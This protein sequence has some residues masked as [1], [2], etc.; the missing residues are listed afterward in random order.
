MLRSRP[1]QISATCSIAARRCAPSD[2]GSEEALP[3][4][5]PIVDDDVGASRRPAEVL[6]L[7]DGQI[8]FADRSAGRDERLHQQ[9]G[10]REH[11]PVRDRRAGID[12][13]GRVEPQPADRIGAERDLGI[14]AQGAVHVG[15]P[16]PAPPQA[17]RQGRARTMR[18]RLVITA[19]APMPRS[20]W[21][22]RASGRLRGR[23]RTS[24]GGCRPR[25]AR[26][27]SR[28]GSGPGG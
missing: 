19:P 11:V 1:L 16:A 2:S 4:A 22:G 18:T 5:S 13:I 6:E 10:G 28:S 20:K 27:A 12:R 26:R 8:R 3:C 15:A 23:R 17:R 14:D 24:R 9:V 25:R 21:S 7:L